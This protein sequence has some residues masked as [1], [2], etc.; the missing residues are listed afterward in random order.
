MAEPVPR[1][2]FTKRREAARP[3]SIPDVLQMFSREVRFYRELAS[4]VTVRVPACY[5]A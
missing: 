2:T 1:R 3:G 5:L 4:E